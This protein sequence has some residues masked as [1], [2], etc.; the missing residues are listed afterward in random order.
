MFL[1]QNEREVSGGERRV[2][3]D[4]IVKESATVVNYMPWRKNTSLQR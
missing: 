4:E 1:V 2:R 3:G